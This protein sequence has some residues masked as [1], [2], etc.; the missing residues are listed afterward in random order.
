VLQHIEAEAADVQLVAVAQRRPLDRRTVDEDAVEAAVVEHSQLFAGL[1]DD[2]GVA[3]GD[4]GVVEA[5]VGG[6]A[7]ADAGPAAFDLEGEDLAGILLQ[8]QAVAR[9]R[10]FLPR[11]L[12]PA[13]CRCGAGD[14]ELARRL[15]VVLVCLEDRVAAILGAATAGAVG[16]PVGL[17]QGELRAADQ[18]EEGALTGGCAG[19]VAV[20]E[21]GA[22]DAVEDRGLLPAS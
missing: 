16:E 18:A 21:R 20:V 22:A 12:Q 11:I 1:G 17:D 7:A 14:G 6:E 10:L 19:G 15:A 2:Q 9:R 4:A 5:Q 3:A 8:G 13:R